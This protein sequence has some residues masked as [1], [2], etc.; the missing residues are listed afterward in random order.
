MPRSAANA[1]LLRHSVC[2]RRK[3]V[4]PAAVRRK[5]SH[6]VNLFALQVSVQHL[7]YGVSAIVY[8]MQHFSKRLLTRAGLLDLTCTVSKPVH[9]VG[10]GT[11]G[12]IAVV[13]SA[14]NHDTQH[15]QTRYTSTSCIRA[16]AGLT[17][18]PLHRWLSDPASLVTS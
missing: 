18:S 13:K 3:N 5:L 8:W 15:T 6:P 7:A 14:A 1:S 16:P 2:S 17:E 10:V 4:R 12:S 9:A 11:Q